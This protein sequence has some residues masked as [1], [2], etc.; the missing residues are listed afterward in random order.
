MSIRPQAM[1][2]AVPTTMSTAMPKTMST[3]MPAVRPTQL[4][5][6][7]P[8]L[9]RYPVMQN[10]N[11]NVQIRKEFTDADPKSGNVDDDVI[12]VF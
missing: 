7:A 9:S 8:N 12:E 3:A 6:Q 4:G 11:M 5:M 2:T 10:T 1:S